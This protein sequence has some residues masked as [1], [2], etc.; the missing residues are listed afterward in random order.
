[1]TN[2]MNILGLDNVTLFCANVGPT[3]VNKSD[4]WIFPSLGEIGFFFH[5]TNDQK[6]VLLKQ[7]PQIRCQIEN[8]QFSHN[9]DPIG[10]I[11][12]EYF[13]F[14]DFSLLYSIEFLSIQH[15]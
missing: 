6:G 10:G 8:L 14:Q 2:I 7:V 1:M 3:M 15:K 12:S 5:F 4:K 11:L 13:E 9:I